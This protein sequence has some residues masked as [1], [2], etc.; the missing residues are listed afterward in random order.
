MKLYIK[1]WGI[2]GEGIGYVKNKPVFVEGAMP[3]ELVDV[4]ITSQNGRFAN[5][6]INEILEPSPRRRNPICPKWEQC[7][8]CALSHVDYKGQVRMKEASLKE[9]LRKYA[10]YTGPIEPLIKNPNALGYRNALKLPFGYDGSGQL[11]SG[12]YAAGGK[13]FVPLERCIIHTKPLEK[14]RQEL[15]ELLRSYGLPVKDE[16]HPQGLLSLV[17][18]E[19]DGKVHIILVTS[20]EFDLTPDQIDGIL[21]LENVESLWQSLKTEKEESEPDVF[22][23]QM[24]HLG[25]AQEID[26]PFAGL[27]LKLLPRSFFQLNTAQAKNLYEQVVNLIPDTNKLLI[28]AYS[29]IGAISLLGADKADKIIGIESIPDAV[30]NAN[31]NARLNH[32]EN[33]EFV[34][35]DAA[36]K[37]REITARTH[38]KTIVVD[39]PRGGLNLE[40]LHALKKARPETIIYVSCNPSTL[41]KDLGFLKDLYTIEKVQPV[42]MF[43]QTP[44]IETIVLLSRNS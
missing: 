15:T 34:C 20:P 7:G 12:M 19:F 8:G 10:G 33:V 35:G 28:E 24:R 27:Q 38:A 43:S 41:A 16:A 40:M 13:E 21:A 30:D 39:P 25:G 23:S 44:H 6:K 22:G 26:F 1:R 4:T 36:K 29:G 2:N 14:A 5:A 18:K 31:E 42:D 11:I 9:A 3:G 37:L 17:M 32:K